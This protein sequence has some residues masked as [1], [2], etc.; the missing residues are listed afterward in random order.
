MWVYRLILCEV[1]RVFLEKK[2]APLQ[3]EDPTLLY[4]S[5]LTTKEVI[6]FSVAQYL[7]TVNIRAKNN[8]QSSY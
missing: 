5:N 6:R 4:A 8:A 3:Q 7:V 2:K 1:I